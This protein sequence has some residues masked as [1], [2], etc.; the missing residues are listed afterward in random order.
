MWVG[1]R[2]RKGKRKRKRN[3]G[4]KGRRRRL[5]TCTTTMV[6]IHTTP[7]Y[8]GLLGH[9]MLVHTTAGALPPGQLSYEPPVLHNITKLGRTC[10]ERTDG[11]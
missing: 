10:H 6:D 5:G 1:E 9:N 11:Q 7:H 2:K 8:I 4:E 3:S